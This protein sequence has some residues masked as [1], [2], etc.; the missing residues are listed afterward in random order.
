VTEIIDLKAS[1]RRDGGVAFTRQR[2]RTSARVV[3]HP[4][5]TGASYKESYNISNNEERFC[6]S[7]APPEAARVGAAV[8]GRAGEAKTDWTKPLARPLDYGH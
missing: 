5:D 4:R 6:R 2:C 7:G 3:S 8:R 1:R